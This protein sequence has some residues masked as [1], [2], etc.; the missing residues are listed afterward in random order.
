V[1]AYFDKKAQK[2]KATQPQS[3]ALRI[4]PAAGIRSELGGAGPGNRPAVSGTVR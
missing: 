1:K 3:I 2:A 4:P